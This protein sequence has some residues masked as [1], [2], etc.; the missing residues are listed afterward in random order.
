MPAKIRLARHGKKG[1]AYFHIVVADGRAPRNGRFIEQIGSYNPNA[2]P[3][4]IEINFEK[5]LT[6]LKNGAQPTDT[7][8]AILSYKGVLYKD[9]LNRGVLKGA[10]TQEQADAKFEQW[11]SQKEAKI[12]SK[13]Q[14]VVAEKQAGLKAGLAAETKAK[15]NKA[16]AIAAKQKPPVV[17]AVAEP[18]EAPAA[19]ADETAATPEA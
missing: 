18:A 5:A 19:A 2:N 4:V 7:T 10:L 15:E 14:S 12:S 13:A 17:E 9:H 6:W 1:N 16:E 11:L 8:R 3:A